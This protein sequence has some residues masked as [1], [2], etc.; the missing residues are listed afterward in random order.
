MS[1]L[2]SVVSRAGLREIAAVAVILLLV[3]WA[4]NLVRDP[5]GCTN[6]ISVGI[7]DR[8]D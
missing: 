8:I 3:I 6:R 1:F 7:N 2:E 4:F 5:V